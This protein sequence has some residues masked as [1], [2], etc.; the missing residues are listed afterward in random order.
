M[1][2]VNCCAPLFGQLLSQ[3]ISSMFLVC[4]FHEPKRQQTETDKKKV[5]EKELTHL[6][7]KIVRFNYVYSR[8]HL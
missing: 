2:I 4:K 1:P 7:H 3:F 5:T 6:N 8:S